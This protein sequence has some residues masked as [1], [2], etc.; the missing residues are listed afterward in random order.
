M[1]DSK[2][3]MRTPVLAFFL[4]L[5]V[6]MC[7]SGSWQEDGNPVCTESGTQQFPDAIPD[8]FGGA[9]I[10]WE[11]SR[12]VDTDI[13]AQRVNSSGS[14]LW[15]PGGVPVCTTS[16]GQVLPEITPDGAG[17]AFIVWED[18]RIAGGRAYVQRVDA[19]GAVLWA[20]NGIP[21]CTTQASQINPE[22]TTDESGG[23]VVVW[24]D[25]RG[26]GET[27][28]EIYAQRLDASGTALWASEGVAASTAWGTQWYPELVPD[29]TGGAIITWADRR[30]WNSDV[31]VQR[32]DGT[33]TVLWD[34][35]GAEVCL[36]LLNQQYPEIVS[37]GSG[38]AIMGWA[39]YREGDSNPD[40]YAQHV[41]A[42]GAMSWSTGGVPVCTA[43]NLQLEAALAPDGKGGSIITWYDKRGGVGY[44]I[45]VQRVD[46]LGV[47]LWTA[48][49]VPVCITDNFQEWPVIIPDGAGGAVIAWHDRGIAGYD[50]YAQ[51]VDSLGSALW[52]SG[53]VAMCTAAGDQKLPC[54][55]TDEQGGAIIA[56]HDGRNGN[57]DIYA[58]RVS[59]NGCGGPTGLAFVSVRVAA[60]SGAVSLSWRMG[61]DVSA[62]DFLIQRSE[63]LE[64]SFVTLDVLVTRGEGDTFFC[65]DHGVLPGKTY[66]YKIWLGGVYG[67][68]YYGPVRIQVPPLPAEYSVLQSYPNPFNPIC[69]IR[70]EIPVAGAVRLTVFDASGAAVRTLVNAWMP[71]GVHSEVWD[72]RD[73]NGREVPSGVYFYRMQAADFDFTRKAVL[74]R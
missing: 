59:A 12:G 23:A 27:G 67:S 35:D 16:G 20:T 68:E 17:G 43:V 72:G 4:C 54:I 1:D 48:D 39:D 63:S 40:I 5:L 7:A 47:P 73:Q 26:G 28:W 49:G 41:D 6:P 9:I 3:L 64:D 21:V 13:Y 24:Q 45:Y 62:G 57:D 25:F 50:I 56:W 31:Y 61:A 29:G 18:R 46:T 8:G 58:Q 38:G 11:D 66:W 10:V 15:L 34:T 60:T 14:I 19:S 30:N 44:D 70:Y 69:T 42:S 22:I 32:I 2:R 51:K 52:T 55:T 53:G 71:A 33:G 65:T 36:V 37:D 74:L